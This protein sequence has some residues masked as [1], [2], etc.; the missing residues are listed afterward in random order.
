MY[1]KDMQLVGLFVHCVLNIVPY[2]FPLLIS[3]FFSSIIFITFDD[4]DAYITFRYLTLISTETSLRGG[5]KHDELVFIHQ[6][7]TKGGQ[8]RYDCNNV[9]IMTINQST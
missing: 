5:D 7:L 2:L 9:T 3:W 1:W 8:S 6:A 4:A